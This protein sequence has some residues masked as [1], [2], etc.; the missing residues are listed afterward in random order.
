MDLAPWSLGLH[1]QFCDKPLSGL[2]RHF[3]S[4]PVGH[5]AASGTRCARG[6]L[7]PH[8]VHGCTGSGQAFEVLAS[9]AAEILNQCYVN[10]T[11]TVQVFLIESFL[12]PRKTLPLLC[13]L[14]GIDCLSG[15]SPGP[16]IMGEMC[17]GLREE[18]RWSVRGDRPQSVTQRSQ[19]GITYS[20]FCK[21]AH[22][23][24]RQTG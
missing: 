19:L 8:K 11:G 23:L 22:L 2:P 17:R 13:L 21:Q 10:G 14:I 4:N 3:W 5:G 15:C 6:L 7:V 20:Q 9:G 18:E 12:H 24:Q 16:H 1:Y